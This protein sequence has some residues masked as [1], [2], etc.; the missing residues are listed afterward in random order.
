ML[1]PSFLH[2]RVTSQLALP[3]G[4]RSALPAQPPG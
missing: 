3:I 1:L 2:M 4:S